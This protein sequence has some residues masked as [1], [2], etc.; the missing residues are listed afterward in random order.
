MSSLIHK[1]LLQFVYL[2]QLKHKLKKELKNTVCRK[3]ILRKPYGVCDNEYTKTMQNF[4]RFVLLITMIW[5][6]R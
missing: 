6:S 2:S 5:L 1:Y 4:R 3:E